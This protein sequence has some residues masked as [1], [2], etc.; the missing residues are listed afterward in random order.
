[1]PSAIP[2]GGTLQMIPSGSSNNLYTLNSPT[3]INSSQ[4]EEPV[5]NQQTSM[6]P[7]AVNPY[8]VPYVAGGAPP[9]PR[10]TYTR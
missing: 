10:Y 4:G 6:M 1:M 9:A 2:G 7:S 3:G 5:L 8:G